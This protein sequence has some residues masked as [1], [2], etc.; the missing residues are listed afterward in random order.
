[1]EINAEVHALP[2]F[3]GGGNDEDSSGQHR[4]LAEDT[5]ETPY[6]VEQVQADQLKDIPLP[7]P[8]KKRTVCVVD[9]GYDANHE[10]LPG[11]SYGVNGFVPNGY[12]GSWD[13]DGHGHGTHCAGTIGAIGNNEVG[14]TSVNP[15]PNKF[16]F[17]IGKGLSD[18]GSGTSDGVIEAVEACRANG[19]NIISMSLG[20]GGFSS[21][22][23]DVYNDLYSDDILVIAAAGN[24]VSQLV[25]SIHYTC[26]LYYCWILTQI[27]PSFFT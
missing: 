4:R 7:D 2:Y 19:A 13:V 1:M 18:S 5:E 6:G 20:G 23:N 26:R 17:F 15:D 14:V 25:A 3:R 22:N 9:T 11:A 12:S 27:I 8:D 24:D 16:T 21:I 10:D